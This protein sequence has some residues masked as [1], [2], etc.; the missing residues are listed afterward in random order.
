MKNFHDYEVEQCQANPGMSAYSEFSTIPPE[1]V[2][3]SSLVAWLVSGGRLQQIPRELRV[4]RVLW[5]AVRNDKSSYGLIDKGMVSDHRALSLEAIRCDSVGFFAVPEAYKDEDFLIEMAISRPRLILCVDLKDKYRHLVTE[6]TA[7]GICSVSLSLA[8]DYAQMGGEKAQVL[9]TDK[10]LTEA[11]K[12]QSS[13]YGV[14]EI[15]GRGDLLI[16]MLKQG[17]WPDETHFS[18]PGHQSFKNPPSDVSDALSRI[19]RTIGSMRILHRNWLKT[20]PMAEVVDALE[21]SRQGLDELFVLY[22][23]TDLRGFM[24]AYRSL[25]GR[26]V[27]QDLGM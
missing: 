19:L 9:V 4:E 17:F 16:S 12:S 10:L 7:R 25:R 23:E 13:D 24:K 14:L 8:F 27:E 15:M 26:F 18:F 21:G 3:E 5:A 20:Q 22:P 11:I 6:K 1:K 2:S